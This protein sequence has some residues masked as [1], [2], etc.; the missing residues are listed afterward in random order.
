MSKLSSVTRAAVV[1]ALF[2]GVCARAEATTVTVDCSGATPGA[3]T[4][5]NA[6]LLSLPATGSNTVLVSGTCVEHV[7]VT[8]RTDLLIQGN[9]GATLQAPPP[10]AAT[11]PALVVRL[12]TLVRIENLTITGGFLRFDDTEGSFR[13]AIENSPANGLIVGGASSVLIFPSTF[14]AN[15]LSGLLI[16][17]AGSA[18]VQGGL[19]VEDN[20]GIGIT[21][22]GVLRLQTGAGDNVVRRNGAGIDLR[23]G[24]KLVATG[25]TSVLDN[26]TFGIQVGLGTTA[27]FGAATLPSGPRGMIISGNASYGMTIAGSAAVGMVGPHLIAQNGT[28][29][30]ESGGVRVGSTSRIQFDGD[31]E[32]ADNIGPGLLAEWNAA[33]FFSG[34]TVRGNTAEGIRI[35]RGSVAGVMEGTVFIGN[36]AGPLTCDTTALV[37]GTAPALAGVHP[38]A[39]ARVERENG[40]PRPGIVK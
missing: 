13:G 1:A 24:A 34:T 19:V 8:A 14:R 36:G 38:N 16:E 33:A 22:S 10:T 6:A 31:V 32:I 25:R 40:K 7:Q 21:A 17:P 12:S 28:P 30:E 29:S 15:A 37:S 5:I 20:E 11:T 27:S 23:N 26:Y 4:S 2:T 35:T 18:T 9:P 39:C 3:F